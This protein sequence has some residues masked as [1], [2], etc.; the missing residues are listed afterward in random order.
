MAGILGLGL[1]YAGTADEGVS[2]YLSPFVADDSASANMEVRL[3]ALCRAS[4]RASRL[5]GVVCW[6]RSLRQAVG[7]YGGSCT[8]HGV[9]WHS[10]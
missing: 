1:A 6:A 9:C 7:C 5:T 2:E 10:G 8:G 3:L 4:S